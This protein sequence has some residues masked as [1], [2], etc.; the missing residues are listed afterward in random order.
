MG[1]IRDNTGRDHHI[2]AYTMWVAGG[3]FRPGI[4]HGVSDELGLAV[5]KQPVHVHDLQATLLH[6]LGLNHEKLTFRFQGRDFRLTDVHGKVV[7]EI[8]SLNRPFPAHTWCL[9][10]RGGIVLSG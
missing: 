5:E 1:E 8:V 10:V 2:D 4:I 9:H 7:H 3:G 6:Q